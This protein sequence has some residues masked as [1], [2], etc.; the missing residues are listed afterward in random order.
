MEKAGAA[1]F[2][3][4]PTAARPLTG[5]KVLDLTRVLA[6]PAATRFLTSSR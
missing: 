3:W 5:I 1:S 6:G 2:G 4:R